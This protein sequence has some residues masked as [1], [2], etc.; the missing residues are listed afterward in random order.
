MRFSKLCKAFLLTLMVVY[1]SSH[2]IATKLFH[3]FIIL[4]YDP[5]IAWRTYSLHIP[6]KPRNTLSIYPQGNSHGQNSHVPRCIHFSF[7][8]FGSFILIFKNIKG[9]QD[10]LYKLL[11]IPCTLKT[12][13]STLLISSIWHRFYLKPHD[14]WSIELGPGLAYWWLFSCGNRKLLL[15]KM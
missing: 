5:R 13:S 12:R 4:W 6:P 11:C 2:S 15:K 8:F 3:G 9:I 7:F 14:N 10:K 1:L